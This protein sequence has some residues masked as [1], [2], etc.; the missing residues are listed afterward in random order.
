MN[1]RFSLAVLTFLTAIHIVSSNNLDSVPTTL[2]KL[3][4]KITS[5]WWPDAM[6]YSVMSCSSATQGSNTVHPSTLETLSWFFPFHTTLILLLVPHLLPKPYKTECLGIQSERSS[7][8]HLYI[9]PYCSSLKYLSGNGAQIYI[10]DPNLS[11]EYQPDSCI[12][13]WHILDLGCLTITS[14]LLYPNHRTWCFSP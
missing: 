1:T 14:S 9:L 13:S 2:L 3:L 11:P 6:G 10:F 8:S 12:L 4:I 5:K 7:L